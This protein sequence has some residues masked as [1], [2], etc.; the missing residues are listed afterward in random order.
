MANQEGHKVAVANA[1]SA[2]QVSK[3]ANNTQ[4]GHKVADIAF[5]QAVLAS[6]RA[7]G[8]KTN[9]RAALAA[10]GAEDGQGQAGD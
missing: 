9:A 8:I 4:A 5:Y 3:A 2:R 6:G 1:E 10:L 7:N